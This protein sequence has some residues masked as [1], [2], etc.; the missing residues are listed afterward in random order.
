MLTRQQHLGR[1]QSLVEA[2]VPS[3]VRAGDQD[4]RDVDGY[5]EYEIKPGLT[6]V[7]EYG[8]H[9]VFLT[10]SES[11]RLSHQISCSLEYSET[12]L[13]EALVKDFFESQAS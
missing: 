5:L 8:E 3:R 13:G 6:C 9:D 1:W 7:F 4:F 12:P 10:W 11:T 2:Y